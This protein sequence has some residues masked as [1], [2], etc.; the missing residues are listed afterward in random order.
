MV[1][2][3]VEQP[4]RCAIAEKRHSGGAF[5]ATF[6]AV[7]VCGK[8]LR[9]FGAVG[10]RCRLALSAG[11]VAL[12]DEAAAIAEESFAKSGV[13]VVDDVLTEETLVSLREFLR[14]STIFTRAYVQGYLGAFLA[15]GFGGSSLIWR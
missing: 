6:H 11:V 5:L 2:R 8:S 7:V 9:P 12:G 3:R 13:A 10:W 15:D 14:G 1:Q 4:A